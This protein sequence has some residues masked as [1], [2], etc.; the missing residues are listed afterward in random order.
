MKKFFENKKLVAVILL[1]V[2]YLFYIIFG[3]ASRANRVLISS[4]WPTLIV[5]TLLIGSLIVGIFVPFLKRLGRAAAFGLFGYALID[6]A[7]SYPAFFVFTDSGDSLSNAMG[8]LFGIGG[9]FAILALLSF[10]LGFAI[11][12]VGKFS[13]VI[14]EILAL[15]ACLFLFVAGFLC[16]FTKDGQGNSY[17]YSAMA[18]LARMLL[19]AGGLFAFP[20]AL[21]PSSL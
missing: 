10:A 15:A 18:D 13:I 11:P 17:W 21:E 12:L 20:W 7:V 3:I 2:A 19:L 8:I 14:A 4:F 1:A 9:I 5:W 6:A 16:F